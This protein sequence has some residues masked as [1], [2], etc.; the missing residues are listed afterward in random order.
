MAKTTFDT[1]TLD[2]ADRYKLLIGLVVPRPIGWVGTLG[3]DGTRNLAPFSFFNV[4]SGTPPT[5]LFSPGRRH[6]SPKDSLHNALETGEFTINL[7]DENL[8]EAMNVTSGEYGPDV[9]EF[10][11]AGLEAAPGDIV[12]AP[13]VAASPANFECLVTQSVEVGDP[14]SN[15]VVFGVI[16]RVH[17][18]TDLL[19][20]TRV[21]P[22]GL[23]AVGRMAGSGY[24]RTVD[25]Y[26]E[27]ERPG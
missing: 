9:D 20:G 10:E 22:I 23:A 13:L 3:S 24:T 1:A 4:V 21:D 18:R 16:A 15:T 6:G 14:P 26:F 25:G 8:A 11:L 2:G 7:V 5:V 27:M 12:A 19:D 17:V